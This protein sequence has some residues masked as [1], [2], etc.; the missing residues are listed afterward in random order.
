M[1]LKWAATS[2]CEFLIKIAIWNLIKK[3]S[4]QQCLAW[5]SLSKS[6][7]LLS[8]RNFSTFIAWECFHISWKTINV[9][10]QAFDWGKITSGKTCL[11][12]Q[13][14]QF[15]LY[16]NYL[17]LRKRVRWDKLKNYCFRWS[18]IVYPTS[19]N[20]SKRIYNKANQNVRHGWRG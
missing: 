13:N 16:F 4:L 3:S 15:F 5:L 8:L 9:L 19:D 10:W 11:I 2:V 18:S 20:N 6:Y 12:W 1:M 14:K 7:H 17:L